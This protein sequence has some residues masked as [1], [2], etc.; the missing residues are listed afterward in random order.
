[1]WFVDTFTFLVCI[2][3]NSAIP[4]WGYLVHSLGVHELISENRN[5]N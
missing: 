3:Y 5:Y 4:N 1:M 2:A